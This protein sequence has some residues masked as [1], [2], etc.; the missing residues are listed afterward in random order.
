M[1]IQKKW[2]DYKKENAKKEPDNFGAYQLAN[3]NREILYI[4]EGHVKTRLI[5]HFPNASEPVVC[6]SFY[7]YEL[8]KSKERCRQRQNA[9]LKEYMDS[10]NGSTPPFNTRSRN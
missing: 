9:L 6:A 10:N 7:R 5:A 2:S 8:T 4:G 1:P 3:K